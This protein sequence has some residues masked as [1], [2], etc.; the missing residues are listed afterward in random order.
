M[1]AGGKKEFQEKLTDPMSKA[2]VESRKRKI[3]Y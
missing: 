3:E 1:K 2:T